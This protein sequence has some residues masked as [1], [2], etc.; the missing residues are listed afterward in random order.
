MIPLVEHEVERWEAVP[1]LID[2]ELQ[3]I[4]SST[5]DSQSVGKEIRSRTAEGDTVEKLLS[6]LYDQSRFL[7]RAT[8]TVRLKPEG[9]QSKPKKPASSL[10]SKKQPSSNSNTPLAPELNKPPPSK[11]KDPSPEPHESSKRKPALALTTSKPSSSKQRVHHKEATVTSTA[12]GNTYNSLVKSMA[13][14]LDILKVYYMEDNSRAAKWV[15][16]QPLTGKDFKKIQ[17][18]LRKINSTCET[19]VVGSEDFRE[20]FLR[21]KQGYAATEGLVKCIQQEKPHSD[22]QDAWDLSGLRKLSRFI[23]AELH[24]WLS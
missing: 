18:L 5:L 21:R 15:M 24:D 14:A 13:Y 3:G 16:E 7:D 10:R 6:L 22:P 2:L 4:G 20:L 23:S 8:V 17:L 12:L 19:D 1:T 11:Q 9:P